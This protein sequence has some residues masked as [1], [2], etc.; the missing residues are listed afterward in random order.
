MITLEKPRGDLGAR[1]ARFSRHALERLAERNI[2]LEAVA[3]V[4][5]EP[6][7]RELARDSAVRLAAP[8]LVDGKWAW[9]RVVVRYLAAGRPYVITCY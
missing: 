2:G 6:F 3:H 9:V 4:L 8:C 1:E 5:D 7:V